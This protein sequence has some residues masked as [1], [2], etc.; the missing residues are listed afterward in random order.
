MALHLQLKPK[1][2]TLTPIRPLSSSIPPSP[3]PPPPDDSNGDGQPKPPSPPSF[4][5]IFSDIKQSLKT[6]PSPLRRIPTEPSP[7]YPPFPPSPNPPVSSIDDIRRKLAEL[8]LKSPNSNPSPN[9]NPNPNPNH[10]MSFQELF[11]KSDAANKTGPNPSGKPDGGGGSLS[12]ESIRESLRQFRSSPRENTGTRSSFHNSL[13]LKSLQ[14]SLWSPSISAARLPESIFGREL[15]EKNKG[16]APVEEAAAA[17]GETKALKTEFVKM[18]T[19]EELGEKL[20]R[21]RPAAAGKAG[22]NWFSLKELNGRLAKLR[23]QEEG[24]IQD[25]IGGVLFVD[26]KETLEK[27]KE[28]D[29]NKNVNMRRL[30]ILTNLGTNATPPFMLKPP[31]EQLVE[32]YFHPDHLSSAEKMKME[33]QKVRDEFKMSESDCGSSRVQIAQLTTKIKHLSSVL[34]KKDKHSRKGLHEMV[35]RRKKLLK[36]LRRTDWDSYCLVLSK[37]GLRDVPEYKA[38]NYK[39]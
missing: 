22:K 14:E 27:L 21:L 5:A 29:A 2:L 17:E 18:Y 30:S 10:T 32:N 16:D 25:R 23:K 1:T 38:P 19:P 15:R 34:H 11:N 12:Y 20:R 3:P 35:Q 9:P 28:A 37:L 4:S 36:Y 8:R 33:L 39:A 6:P 31:Q 7:P 26:L 13:N 24:E